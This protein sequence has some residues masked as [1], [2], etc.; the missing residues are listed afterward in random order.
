[1]S[2]PTA[3][4]QRLAFADALRGL[5]AL[6]VVLFHVAAGQHLPALQDRLAGPAMDLL[7]THGH[8]GVPVFFVLSGFV[9][10]LNLAGR[11]VT[12]STAAQFLARRMVRLTPPYYVAIVLALAYLVLWGAV[13]GQA[14][15]FPGAGSLLAH[16]AYLQGVLSIPD[17]N[18]VFWTLC[19]EVQFYAVFALLAWGCHRASPGGA[20]LPWALF[21]SFAAGLAWPLG[22][23]EDPLW[24][25]G[26]VPYWYCFAAG[27]LVYWGWQ[28]RGPVRL[29]AM[30]AIGLLWAV[31]AG[32][33]SGYPLVSALTATLL[34]AAG[35]GRRMDRWLN[36]PAL[37]GL[38]RISYS[39]YLVH[40]LVIGAGFFVIRLWLPE[41]MLRELVGLVAV[42]VASVLVS[43]LLYR[44]VELPSIGWSR[45]VRLSA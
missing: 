26:F 21:A 16:A 11:K 23:V 12:G 32:T 28:V 35:L 42:L 10:A 1:M 9:M 4:G 20:M 34:L 45:R 6:W 39:L 38:G 7:F 2:P 19:V 41:G 33:G 40:N 30:A 43:G 31:A 8:L 22:G 36:L 44:W 18:P 29:L 5:A 15:E 27:A 24:P 3:P 37:Q 17:I 25:G 13:R 14:P